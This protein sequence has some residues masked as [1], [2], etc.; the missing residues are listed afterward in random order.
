[1]AGRYIL[2]EG[3]RWTYV[4]PFVNERLV[5]P[6]EGPNGEDQSKLAG[7]R[8]WACTFTALL[9]GINF[10]FLGDTR[11]TRM[12]QQEIVDL[13]FASGDATLRDGSNTVQMLTALRA[14]YGETKGSTAL[15]MTDIM[16]RLRRGQMLVAGLRSADMSDHFRRWC[17][18][19]GALHRAAFVGFRLANGEPQTRIL[20][21]MAI[22]SKAHYPD[23]RTYAGEWLPMTEYARFAWSNQ[24]VWFEPGEFLGPIK[25]HLIRSFPLGRPIRFLAGAIVD[26]YDPIHPQ[27][28]V[29]RKRFAATSGAHFDRHVRATVGGV[30]REYV[31]IVDGLFEDLLIP[32]DTERIE[33]N[34]APDVPAEDHLDLPAVELPDLDPALPEI[35]DLP[36]R[37]APGDGSTTPIDNDL[38][39]DPLDEAQPDEDRDAVEADEFGGARPLAAV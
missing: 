25:P 7:G 8:S 37:E 34:V 36:G 16:D 27:R 5:G 4:P 39:D 14:R 28:P 31:R 33:A 24:Q 29:L 38:D 19:T 2:I 15:G 9:Y 23:P 11:F 22:P 32:L 26:A 35:P 21:P 20:D 13:A 18:N 6:L 12:T 1:M 10:A 30:K 3:K 17:G